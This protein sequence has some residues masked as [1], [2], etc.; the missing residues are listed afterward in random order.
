MRTFKPAA[1]RVYLFFRLKIIIFGSIMKT[2]AKIV[3]QTPAT[4]VVEV[5]ATGIICQSAVTE[6]YLYVGLDGDFGDLED[7]LG[8]LLP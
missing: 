5:R 1:Q 2:M 7:I 8:G 4:E 3:Y 6:D